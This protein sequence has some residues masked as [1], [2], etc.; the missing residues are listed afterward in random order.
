MMKKILGILLIGLGM[1]V[2]AQAQTVSQTATW[3][4]P[5]PPAQAQTFQYFLG[6]SLTPL[7]VKLPTICTA[8]GAS[9]ACMATIP[10][11]FSDG[12]TVL[13]KATFTLYAQAANGQGPA[14]TSGPL[15]YDP[16]LAVGPSNPGGFQ[17][18]I[19]NIFK[20]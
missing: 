12:T 13:V 18:N 5:E 15:A 11:K 6:S 4:Q 7:T 14:G 2:S 16:A 20:Q 8:Q 19:I 1:A 17:I 10:A 3:T 9:S